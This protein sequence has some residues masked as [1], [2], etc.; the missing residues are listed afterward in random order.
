MKPIYRT[1][2]ANSVNELMIRVKNFEI[3]GW[4]TFGEAERINGLYC[5]VMCKGTFKHEIELQ[6]VGCD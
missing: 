3:K 2:K 5:Q 6:T 4:L 1:I